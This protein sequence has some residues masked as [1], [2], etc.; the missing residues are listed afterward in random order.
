MRDTDVRRLRDISRNPNAW[1]EDA[2][3]NRRE[4]CMKKGEED[5]YEMAIA[6]S[7]SVRCG[8]DRRWKRRNRAT[9]TSGV[10]NGPSKGRRDWWPGMTQQSVGLVLGTAGLSAGPVLWRFWNV[11]EELKSLR[12]DVKEIKQTVKTL[13]TKM[14]QTQVDVARSEG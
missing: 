12:E 4:K 11:P 7:L 14:W 13:E 8:E 1:G 9:T 2:R 6:L 5:K 10:E 3:K